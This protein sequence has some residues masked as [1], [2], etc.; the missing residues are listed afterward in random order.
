MSEM[1]EYA[2][3]TFC[4]AELVADNADIAK[5]FYSKLFGWNFADMPIGDGK[6]YSMASVNGKDAGAMYQMWSEQ[7]E[8]GVPTHWASYVSVS[9]VDEAVKEAQLLGGGTIVGPMDVFD[10]GRL[11]ILEPTGAAVSLWQPLKHIGAVS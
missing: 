1:K 3:G 10:A 2:P 4:W 9:N 8:Q 11:A 5:E 6:V 7:K